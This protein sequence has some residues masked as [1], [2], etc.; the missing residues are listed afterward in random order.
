MIDGRRTAE[1]LLALIQNLRPDSAFHRGNG[2]WSPLERLVNTN[3]AVLSALRSDFVA[4]KSKRSARRLKV[5]DVIGDADR[6]RFEDSTPGRLKR[7]FQRMTSAGAA[8]LEGG[9]DA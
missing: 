8:V 4:T 6:K 7:A 3:T 5:V 2:A 1:W 9:D